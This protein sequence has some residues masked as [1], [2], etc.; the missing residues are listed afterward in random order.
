MKNDPIVVEQTFK[1]SIER[2][3]QA[4]TDIKQ[5]K[6]WFFEDIPSFKA[7]VG[8]ETQFNVQA[9]DKNYLHIWKVT[10]VQPNKKIIYNWKY[11]GYS[12]NSYVSWELSEEE[13]QTKLKLTHEGSDTFPQ[14]NPDFRR[15]ACMGG[16]DFFVRQR[17]KDFL[18]H[19]A[20]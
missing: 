19:E 14:D 7:E 12:G 9:N 11:G 8:F 20:K 3:W 4:I 18:E 10:A 2:V 15:A 16:W 1:T 6:K 5:M 13:D 17:L